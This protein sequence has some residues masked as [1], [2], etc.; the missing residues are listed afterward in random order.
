MIVCNGIKKSYS[1]GGETVAILN[2]VTLT[3]HP[4]EFIAI[5]GPSGSGKSTLMNIMGL[6]DTVSDGELVINGVNPAHLSDNELARLRATTIGFVFQQFNLLPRT[7]ALDNVALPANYS[8]H[9]DRPQ[10]RAQTLLNTVG[11]SHRLT[12]T[13]AQLS[14]GQQQRVAIARAMMNNPSIIFADEPTGNLDSGS[15]AD[16]MGIF[17]HL[18]SQ[19]KTVILITH[20]A[21]VAAMAHRVVTL[22][23]GE[24]LSD[25]THTP[26]SVDRPIELESP[27][28]VSIYTVVMRRMGADFRQALRSILSHGLRSFLSM[29]GIL[30]GVAS[31][32]TML[33]LGA[34]AKQDIEKRLAG[35]GSNLLIVSTGTSRQGAVAMDPGLSTRLDVMDSALLKK[36]IHGIAEASP[37]VSG[38]VRVRYRN[39]NTSTNLIGALPQYEF[40][41]A[42]TPTQGQFFS[43]SD[44][45]SRR[46]V[47]LIG[48]TLAKNIFGDPTTGAINDNPVGKQICIDRTIFTVIGLLPEK[49]STG[50]RDN[51]DVVV[52]PLST[53][54]NRVLGKTFVDSI[55]IE[56]QS[57]EDLDTKQVEINEW[58]RKRHR[59]S[60]KDDDAIR[61]RNMADIQEAMAQTS[62]TMSILLAAIAVISLVV[63]G[64]GVMNIMLVTVTERTREIGLRKAL[65]ATPGAILT[66]FLIESICIS[67]SGGILGIGIG[68]TITQIFSQTAGWLVV[69]TPSA[70]LGAFGFSMASGIC[71]GFWPAKTASGLNPIESLRH[72]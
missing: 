54:M 39:K 33:G 19:G 41:R 38:K 66:Q 11:L 13:P 10:G 46:R 65:G 31:L 67:V 3:I 35:L 70:L 53:A 34:G 64:I 18:N 5:I 4:G 36:D 7:S 69:L 72:E 40:I 21:E 45:R 25:I 49:G 71:F 15:Q 42:M 60:D 17:N 48:L 14:G 68:V 63:G 20:D 43:Q 28:N 29:L 32:I 8:N 16:I 56:M 57:R 37:V 24:I 61:I 50:F 9:V 44:H 62:Q 1:I 52:V 59:I 27:T 55:E 58:I 30:I 23:D 12:H 51:D 6:L 26:R 47:A 2:G 22:R